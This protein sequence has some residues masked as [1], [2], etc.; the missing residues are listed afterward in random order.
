MTNYSQYNAQPIL[1]AVN[2]C[3]AELESMDTETYRY[4]NPRIIR[5]GSWNNPR[6][7]FIMRSI[8]NELSIFDWWKDT[9][10][11]SQ[12]KEMKKFLETAISLGFTGYV[13]FKVG[14]AGCSNGMWAYK[15]ETTT[16]YSPDCDC[17]Y[18]SFVSTYNYWSGCINGT[19]LSDIPKYKETGKYEF[20]LKEIKAELQ[21]GRVG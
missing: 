7:S 9:L 16:G 2:N 10:S 18:H 4:N 15:E 20:T 3:I 12:V 13:C 17:L 1:N 14:S 19:W 6:Y 11:L 21:K 8:C 5:K